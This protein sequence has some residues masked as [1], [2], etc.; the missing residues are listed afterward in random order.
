M[1]VPWKE[2]WTWGQVRLPVVAPLL[3]GAHGIHGMV[4]HFDYVRVL[5]SPGR[6]GD[7]ADAQPGLTGREV[8]RA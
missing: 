2:W 7:R 6:H 3:V 5:A 8:R 1:R 4:T